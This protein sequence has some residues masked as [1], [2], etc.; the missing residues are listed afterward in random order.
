[1]TTT[2]YSFEALAIILGAT[3]RITSE[4]ATHLQKM[5]TKNIKQQ[6]INVKKNDKKALLG[7]LKKVKSVMNMKST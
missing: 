5:K 7:T 1:M 4:L 2:N 6:L 3:D